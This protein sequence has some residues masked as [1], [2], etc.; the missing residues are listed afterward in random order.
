MDHK[1]G[2]GILKVLILNTIFISILS[3]T[4]FYLGILIEK[5]Y[6]HVSYTDEVSR[7]YIAIAE[8]LGEQSLDAEENIT[9]MMIP[10]NKAKYEFEDYLDGKKDSFFGFDLPDLTILSMERLFWKI[11]KG[12]DLDNLT[13]N[14]L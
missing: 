12:L 8:S 14:L 13:G 7:V 5:V 3:A 9:K 11:E 4:S 2:F 6:R 10:L 1:F